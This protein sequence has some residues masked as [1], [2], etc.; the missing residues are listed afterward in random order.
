MTGGNWSMPGAAHPL[1]GAPM[2]SFNR[3]SR[4]AA[5]TSLMPPPLRGRMSKDS[6]PLMANGLSS[7]TLADARPVRK[8]TLP[9][10]H[11]SLDATEDQRF[12]ADSSR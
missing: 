11:P 8:G 2:A 12:L 3:A 1:T 9:A 10:W 5:W 7:R 6:T 4:C